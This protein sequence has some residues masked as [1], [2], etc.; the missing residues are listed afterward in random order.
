M[1]G[2]PEQRIRGGKLRIGGLETRKI[3]F[4]RDECKVEHRQ[5]TKAKPWM[6]LR[7][8]LSPIPDHTGKQCIAPPTHAFPRDPIFAVKCKIEMWIEQC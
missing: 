4:V 3:W 6:V 5:M 7:G 1:L 8:F 2:P